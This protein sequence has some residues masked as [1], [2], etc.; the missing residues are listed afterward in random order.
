MGDSYI[1][2]SLSPNEKLVHI[3]RFHWIYK[4][5][6]WLSIFWG[7]LLAIILLNLCTNMGSFIGL[8]PMI[9]EVPYDASW[10]VKISALHPGIKILAFLIFIFGLLKFA[11]MMVIMATTEI[12]VTTHRIILKRGLVSR[13]VGEMNTER[14]ESINVMQ[15]ILGRIF[16]Y[17]SLVVHGMGVGAIVTPTI[18]K[19]IV[20]RRAIE[21]SKQN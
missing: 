12:A 1:E 4:L 2:Q 8:S 19:P 13:Y 9:Y 5:Q 6:A 16:D 15:S 10:F 17:G 18:A 11:H 21:H 20:F 3:G 14:I 7:A